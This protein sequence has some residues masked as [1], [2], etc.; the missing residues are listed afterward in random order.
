M[1]GQLEVG[2]GE[3]AELPEQVEI[4]VP[5]PVQLRGRGRKDRE[6][7]FA[8]ALEREV[9]AVRERIELDVLG[10]RSGHLFCHWCRSPLCEHSLPP[11]ERAVFVGYEPTGQPRW[12]DFS[13]WVIERRDPRVER[14]FLARPIPIAMYSAGNE[15]V[16]DL[17]ADFGRRGGP[18]HIVAQVTS[19]PFLLP[20]PGAAERTHLAVTAQLIERRS[21]G[22]EPGY[23]LNLIAAPR[24]PHHLPTLIAERVLPL[25]TQLVAALRRGTV[26]LAEKIREARK[27]GQR[28]RVRECRSHG[29]RAF[30][31]IPQ[32]LEK[33][34]RRGQRR[35]HHAEDRTL[36]PERPTA[37]ALSDARAAGAEDLF[38]DRQENT[39]I[40]RGPRRRI[41]VYRLDG[42]HITSIVYPA[43]TIRERI[44]GGRWTPLEEES[45]ARLR[46][47]L[48]ARGQV[49]FAGDDG[50]DPGSR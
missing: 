38:H 23:S 8:E 27:T 34:L 31:G 35:T 13:S 12:R 2:G 29:R 10:Y 15:L 39:I 45:A 16:A 3:I 22:G 49:P 42:T 41:H 28:I 32:H 30:E 33:L 1:R 19:G 43:K 17:L 7:R 47:G 20:S 21:P 44:R 46:D 37:S 24:T 5:V 9:S 18:Y 50:G 26:D 48:D 11:D 25:L 40:V 36:D 4:R 14:L 6:R